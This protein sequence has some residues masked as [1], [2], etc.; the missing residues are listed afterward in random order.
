MKNP[1]ID[2]L[3]S[4]FSLKKVRK[5]LFDY[6]QEMLSDKFD[7]G[8]YTFLVEEITGLEKDKAVRI[9]ENDV[10]N[11]IQ[12]DSLYKFNTD[13]YYEVALAIGKFKDRDENGFYEVEKCEALLKYNADFSLYDVEFSYCIMNEPEQ[14]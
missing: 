2:F 1:I 13:M 5:D 7:E 8:S 12:Y 4:K 14:K 9:N 10:L 6:L 3:Q 11:I